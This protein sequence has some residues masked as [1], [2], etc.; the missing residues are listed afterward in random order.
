MVVNKKGFTIIEMVVVLGILLSSSLVLLPIG[1]GQLQRN[2][3]DSAAKDIASRIFLYQQNASAGLSD[4]SYGIS[5]STNSYTL[6]TGDSLASAVNS[7]QIDLT[8]N[9]SFSNISIV[10]GGNEMHFN[11]NTFK[12][13]NAGTITI[14]DSLNAY[15]IVVN[16]EG[17][18]Y[19]EL[20]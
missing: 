18:I 10:G 11:K 5:F 17:L 15:T 7:T 12:P 16:Q 14:S 6:Y 9:L 2:K 13:V 8:S 19:V 20:V 3:V 1:I 4:E